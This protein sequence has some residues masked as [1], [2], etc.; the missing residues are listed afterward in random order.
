MD[1]AQQDFAGVGVDPDRGVI[2]REFG[3]ADR[4]PAIP[5]ETGIEH[6]IGCK[7]LNRRR[8]IRGEGDGADDDDA[9]IRGEGEGDGVRRFARH[10]TVH[11]KAGIQRA[12]GGQPPDHRHLLAGEAG[13]LGRRGHQNAAIGL[14]ADPL[15]ASAAEE[16]GIDDQITAGSEAGIQRA[17]GI[18]AIDDQIAA[19]GRQRHDL[20]VGLDDRIEGLLAA[21]NAG[22]DIEHAIRGAVGGEA[23]HDGAGIARDGRQRRRDIDPV[24]AVDFDIDRAEAR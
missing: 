21:R 5:A 2:E 4:E 22:A 12:I 23:E 1:A 20:A 10:G 19:L 24:A 11:T 16:I 3:A 9:A 13:I 18:V 14:H 17:I 6:A 7:A 15:G 8:N